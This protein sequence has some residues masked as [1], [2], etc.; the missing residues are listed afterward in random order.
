MVRWDPVENIWKDEGGVVDVANQTVSTYS[1]IDKYGVFTLAR[2]KDN[3][4][5][6]GNLKVYNAISPNG[7]G[8]N[9]FL[10]IDRIENYPNNSLE[11]FNRWGALVYKATSYNNIDNV[12]D[13]YSQGSLTYKKQE[14]LPTG[15]YFY[16]LSYE[17]NAKMIRKQGH[18]YIND[19]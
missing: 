8:F 11:I 5:L 2:I 13:G 18:L 3:A 7:D 14:K 12:F 9:D 4:V 16:V 6:P 17:Y 10:K 19:N 15:T 1:K